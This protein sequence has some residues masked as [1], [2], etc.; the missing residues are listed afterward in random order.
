[1]TSAEKVVIIDAIKGGDE[2][3]TIYR[4]TPQDCGEQSFKGAL[5]IHD[6]GTLAALQDL[7]L[8]E[9]NTP[10]VVIIGVEPK[11]IDLGMELTPEVD[12]SLPRVLE[13]VKSEI[14]FIDRI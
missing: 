9:E 12:G 8:L 10:T 11:E 3:G 6:L 5:S 13:L 2:P 14:G 1:M 7:A 4:L